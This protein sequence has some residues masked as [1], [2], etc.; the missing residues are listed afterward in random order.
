MGADDGAAPLATAPERASYGGAE[1]PGRAV[2]ARVRTSL[3]AVVRRAAPV[4]GP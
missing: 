3:D 2:P 4:D 1:A